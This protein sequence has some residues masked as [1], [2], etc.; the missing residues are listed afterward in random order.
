MAFRDF[1][2]LGV[3]T[4]VHTQRDPSPTQRRGFSDV[5][6]HIDS[7]NKYRVGLSNGANGSV[8]THKRKFSTA[9]SADVQTVAVPLVYFKLSTLALKRT[10]EV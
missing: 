7:P 1:P 10:F 3:S 9:R 6:M 8:Y 2:T 4:Y 5:N